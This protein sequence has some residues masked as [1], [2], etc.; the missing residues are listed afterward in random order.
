[1]MA[2]RS[3]IYLRLINNCERSSKPIV[4]QPQNQTRRLLQVRQ[5][6]LVHFDQAISLIELVFLSYVYQVYSA[7]AKARVM[8]NN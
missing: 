8:V 7:S 4:P 2:V 5:I 1:M 6:F 3:F